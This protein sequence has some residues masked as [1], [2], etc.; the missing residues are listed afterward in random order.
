MLKWTEAD[1]MALDKKYAEAGISPH[2]RPMRAAV[3]LLGG[4]GFFSV[5][6]LS[7]PEAAAIA[8]AYR[9]LF[10]AIDQTWPG[11]CIGL[12]VSVD[13]VRR[14]TLGIAFGR[15]SV[16]IWRGVGFESQVAWENWCRHD[17]AVAAETAFA[18]ADLHDFSKRTDAIDLV[19]P[20]AAR[21]W[22]M[23]ASNLSDVA[24]VLPTAFSLDSVLQPICLTVEL[25]LKAALTHLGESPWGHKLPGLARDLGKFRPH[26]DDVAIKG[27]IGGF[28]DYVDSRYKPEGLS[29]YQV[30]RLAL[31]AQFIA[32]SS[33]RRLSSVDMALAMENDSWPGPRRPFLLVSS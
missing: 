18:F 23:A 21:L 22:H 5:G 15:P 20:D 16:P 17:P 27:A 24:N 10:P 12:I 14:V 28:P 32:A 33:V 29:R 4:G 25:S 31:A 9:E 3:E 7:N 6:V 19:H 26:R 13:Q 2:Q 1:L 30:V 8:Q 11:A